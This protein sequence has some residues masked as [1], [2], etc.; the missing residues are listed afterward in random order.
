[1]NFHGINGKI[2]SRAEAVLHL[3]DIGFRR[4][5]AAF[6]YLRVINGRPLFMEDHLDR[7]ENSARIL[8]LELQLNRD[9]FQAHL[10]ELAD[11]NVAAEAGLQLFLTGGPAEDG[12]TPVSPQLYVYFT[13]M[14]DRDPTQ[15]QQGAKLITWQ[16]LRDLPEAK[17]TNYLMAVHL[18]NSMREAGAVD[19]LYHDGD[20]AL[21]ATRSNLFVVN[22]NSKVVTPGQ[23]ILAGVTRKNVLRALESQIEVEIRDVTL[24]ELYG[25]QEVF[26][27]STTKGALPIVRLDDRIVG[28]GQPGPITAQVGRLF[29]SWLQRYLQS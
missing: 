23:D 1:M 14:P 6:D 10:L 24:T 3:S 11:L 29:E 28:N 22:E 18:G 7:F 20:R 2:V 21:E 9:D 17:T 13:P 27:T 15:Y 4:S 26:L 25:A 12:F 5:Y 16:Y 19:A 8:G